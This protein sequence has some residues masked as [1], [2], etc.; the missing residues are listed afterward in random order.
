MG[1]DIAWGIHPDKR[2]TGSTCFTD[3]SI[4]WPR[5]LVDLGPDKYKP[6]HRNLPLRTR[7]QSYLS[8]IVTTPACE[9]NMK[10]LPTWIVPLSSK[11]LLKMQCREE[12]LQTGR[13]LKTW[14]LPGT[15]ACQPPRRTSPLSRE[16]TS[17]SG[18]CRTSVTQKSVDA[19]DSTATVVFNNEATPAMAQLLAVA[20]AS[21]QLAQSKNQD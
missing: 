8:P 13:S 14:P 18:K 3:V 21:I 15:K 16:R 11:S 2:D 7:T 20:L 5:T 12:A 9:R 1:W 19:Q 4:Y 17:L 10:H 6:C